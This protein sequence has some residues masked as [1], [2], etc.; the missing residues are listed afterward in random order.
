MTIDPGGLPPALTPLLNAFE[1][2]GFPTSVAL[3]KVQRLLANY[4]GVLTPELLA[5]AQSEVAQL[6]DP[7]I[8]TKAEVLLT[9]EL[10]AFLVTHRSDVPPSDPVN[11]A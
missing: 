1:Q 9:T 4:G 6:L 2:A 7:S 11:L 5:E 3:G 10:L 8:L